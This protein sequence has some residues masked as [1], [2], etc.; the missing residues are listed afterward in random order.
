MTSSSV[1]IPDSCV[2]IGDRQRRARQSRRFSPLELTRHPPVPHPNSPFFHRF[3]LPIIV[4]TFTVHCCFG[5]CSGGGVVRVEF[6]FILRAAHHIY[7][8]AS[9]LNHL[10][11]IRFIVTRKWE[12]NIIGFL[13]LLARG[14]THWGFSKR[15][16]RDWVESEGI[17]RHSSTVAIKRDWR[18]KGANSRRNIGNAI[19]E[20][21]HF[22][23]VSKKNICHLRQIN[24]LNS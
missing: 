6:L 13:I 5:Y 24:W 17:H 14:G 4:V 18:G 20:S 16:Q 7:T 8:S 12:S 11:V 3:A 10:S 21:V 1:T 15:G 22:F 2:S 9:I 19:L 23:L